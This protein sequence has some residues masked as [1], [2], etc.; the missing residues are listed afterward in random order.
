VCAGA[1]ANL[2]IRATLLSDA[3]KSEGDPMS[4]LIARDEDFARVTGSRARFVIA[5]VA[6]LLV[7]DALSVIA[8]L[9]WL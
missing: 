9:F 6:G 8:M 5:A 2:S 4:A 7:A 1:H 3:W